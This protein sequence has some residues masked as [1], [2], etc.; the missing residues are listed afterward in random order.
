MSPF[1]NNLA[2]GMRGTRQVSTR[3]G[4]HYQAKWLR[5]H[6]GLSVLQSTGL[7]DVGSEDRVSCQFVLESLD[8]YF[9]LQISAQYYVWPRGALRAPYSLP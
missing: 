4:L 7:S 8:E 5:N 9:R 6:T 2:T 1:D 3:A